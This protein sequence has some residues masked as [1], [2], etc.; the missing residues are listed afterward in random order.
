MFSAYKAHENITPKNIM[1][2]RIISAL[3]SPL[4]LLTFTLTF[5]SPS[6]LPLNLFPS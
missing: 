3:P 1:F 2:M 5:T 4:P 6:N